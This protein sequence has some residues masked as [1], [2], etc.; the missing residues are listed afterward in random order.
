MTFV[1]SSGLVLVN[2]RTLRFTAITDPLFELK[3]LYG[4][5]QRLGE[6]ALQV[7]RELENRV[8]CNGH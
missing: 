5:A 8:R 4:R 7:G 6:G 3:P 2:Q 1:A